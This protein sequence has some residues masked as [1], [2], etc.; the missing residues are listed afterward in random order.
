MPRPSAP[1]D[2][3]AAAAPG[4]R[5]LARLGL[6]RRSAALLA[7]MSAALLASELAETVVATALPTIAADLGDLRLLALVTTAYLVASTAVLP[8]YGW[9]SDRYGRR[10]LFVVAVALFLVG[11]R[12]RCAGRGPGDPRRSPGSSRAAAPAGCS[13]SCRPRS[14]CSCRCGSG[15]R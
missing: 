9:L 12:A 8:A 3:A 5:G 14:P 1:P 10:R 11:L 4:P 7:G 2:A 6:D 13:C 15:R